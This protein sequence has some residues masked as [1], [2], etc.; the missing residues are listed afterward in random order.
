MLF[1]V[2]LFG[3]SRDWR[4]WTYADLQFTQYTARFAAMPKGAALVIPENPPGW[5]MRL[6]KR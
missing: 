1:A 4:H 6:V 2:M 5:S 3:I